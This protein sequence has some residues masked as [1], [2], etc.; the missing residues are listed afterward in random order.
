MIFLA[1]IELMRDD[2]KSSFFQL[3]DANNTNEASEKVREYYRCKGEEERNDAFL[4]CM[5]DIQI[6][7]MIT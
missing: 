1:E 6:R 7:E 2:Q 5:V 3:V 4:Y